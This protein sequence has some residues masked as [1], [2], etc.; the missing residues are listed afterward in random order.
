MMDK[1]DQK[2]EN[3]WGEFDK[4]KRNDMIFVFALICWKEERIQRFFGFWVTIIMYT[5]LIGKKIWKN[6]DFC[7][8]WEK[9]MK[10]KKIVW[11]KKWL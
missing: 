11:L 8:V 4:R 1:D 2:N 3:V 9:M 5:S 6:W 7:F 10:K